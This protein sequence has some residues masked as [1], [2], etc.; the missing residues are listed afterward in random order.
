MFW[1]RYN[2]ER[3]DFIQ[4]FRP[5]SKAQLLQVAM[6]YHRGDI[7]KAQQMVDFYA[8]NMELPDYDPVPK[9]WQE[10]TK[11]TV[12][13]LIGW[14]KENQDTLTQGYQ[15]IREMVTSRSLPPVEAPVAPLPEINEEV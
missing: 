6:W 2:K 12:N 8:K 4:K 11:E 13:G 1:K 10:S 14:I 5:T 3:M 15:F 7:E 9:S